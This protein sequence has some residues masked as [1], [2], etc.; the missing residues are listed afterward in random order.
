MPVICALILPVCQEFR[1]RARDPPHSHRSVKE[2][3]EPVQ[4][5]EKWIQKVTGNLLPDGWTPGSAKMPQ[6]GFDS[7]MRTALKPAAALAAIY[8][9]GA[10]F[11]MLP[12]RVGQ[13]WFVDAGSQPTKQP[14]PFLPPI[15]VSSQILVA[16]RDKDGRYSVRWLLDVEIM[17]AFGY[18]KQSVST[19]FLGPKTRRSMLVASSGCR[20]H[21]LFQHLRD[22]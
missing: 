14:Q 13:E 1:K 17:T 7:V 2:T 10:F 3:D 22:H 18:P 12:G 6:S 19:S 16:K 9:F 8:V 15:R 5:E 20:L 11:Q 21:I 4:V